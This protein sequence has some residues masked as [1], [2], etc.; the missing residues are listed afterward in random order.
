MLG[1]RLEPRG[2]VHVGQVV[3]E[4]RVEAGPVTLAHGFETAVVGFEN[5]GGSFGI[6][7]HHGLPGQRGDRAMDDVLRDLDELQRLAA[8]SLDH[9]RARVAEW[10]GLFEKRD[11]LVA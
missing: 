2:G 6:D 5:L 11:L 1:F 4:R 3:G 8:R 10:V 7:R 9:H